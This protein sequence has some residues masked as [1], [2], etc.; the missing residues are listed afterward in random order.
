M[1][2]TVRK[3]NHTK[4]AQVLMDIYR[5]EILLRYQKELS[6]YKRCSLVPFK[7]EDEDKFA[8]FFFSEEN[9]KTLFAT[10]D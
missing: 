9:I 4:E 6:L 3:Q 8:E 7:N 10:E 5:Q 1:R 2:I